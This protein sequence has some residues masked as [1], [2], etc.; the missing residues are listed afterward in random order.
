MSSS[1]NDINSFLETFM[2]SY[3]DWVMETMIISWI[4][5]MDHVGYNK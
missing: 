5:L 3:I 2:V 1:R 4:S